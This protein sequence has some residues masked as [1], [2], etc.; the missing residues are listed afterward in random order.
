MELAGKGQLSDAGSLTVSRLLARW[1]EA[2]RP[3]LARG[4]VASYEQHV[5]N[6]IGPRLAASA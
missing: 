2:A 4:T 1:L 3:A 5:D 6:L